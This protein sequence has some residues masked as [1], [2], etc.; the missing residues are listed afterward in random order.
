MEHEFKKKNYKKGYE[1]KGFDVTTSKRIYI[2]IFYFTGLSKVLKTLG[3]C[4]LIDDQGV[5]DSQNKQG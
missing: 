4:R 1:N 5:L 3:G 2:F